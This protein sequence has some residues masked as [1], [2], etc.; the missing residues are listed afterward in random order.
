MFFGVILSLF[1]E[2]RYFHAINLRVS[3]RRPGLPENRSPRKFTPKTVRFFAII[4]IS[5]IQALEAREKFCAKRK[6][7]L[8]TKKFF[9]LEEN[10]SFGADRFLY[11]SI[12]K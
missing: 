10:F 4:N 7:V 12:T 3:G 2:T 6:I 11:V 1:V 5:D 9:S 8:L